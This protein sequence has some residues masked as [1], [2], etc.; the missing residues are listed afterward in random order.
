MAFIGAHS[1]TSAV[2]PLDP[3]IGRAPKGEP[4]VG[5]LGGGLRLPGPGQPC[6]MTIHA[7]SLN[8]SL[9][10][11]AAGPSSTDR[12]LD[13]LE[14]ALEAG[15]AEIDPRLRIADHNVL[16]GVTSDEG[17]GDD[18]PAIRDKV[19]S[20][21]ILVLGT[22]IWLGHPSSYAQRVLERLDA[23]LGEH[24]AGGRMIS[25]GRVALVAVVGNEDGAHHVAAELFQ[26]LA[27]VGFTIPA[28]GMT[29][30]VGRAMQGVDFVDLDEV[31]AEVGGATR[32]AAANGLHLARLLVDEPY[33][34]PDGAEQSGGIGKGSPS[35]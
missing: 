25:S 34:P 31:P 7:L 26:G 29:Y 35:T 6:T 1:P 13:E 28:S 33:P 21:R 2:T 18:W 10:S 24:D 5:D 14:R 27:D 8:C 22:P 30:W 12:L 3:G 9:K 17:S 16:A 20:A 15:G 19:L 23:F 11:S 4:T 32:L